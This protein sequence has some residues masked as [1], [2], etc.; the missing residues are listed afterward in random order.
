MR[1]VPFSPEYLRL[2]DALPFGV[3]DANGRLLLSAGQVVC[4]PGQ[5][6]HLRSQ[7]LFCDEAESANWRR[8]LAATMDRMIRSNV[9]LKSISEALP[10]A[11]AREVGIEVERTLGDQW[12]TVVTQLDAVLRDI[13]P[14]SDWRDRLD[15][16]H[17][18]ARALAARRLDATLY[19]LIYTAGH[20]VERYSC[21][22]ALLTLVIAEQAASLLGW[23]QPDVD[24][25][26]RAALTMNVSMVRLQDLLATTTQAPTDE[27]RREIARHAER[28]AG[29]LADAGASDPLWLGAVRLHHDIGDAGPGPDDSTPAL[30]LARLLRRV[31]IFAAKLSRRATRMPL[32]PVQAAREAC[33]G[34]DG[35]PDEIGAGLLKAVGLYPPGCF[36][37]LACG[38]VG[39]VVSRGRRAN[40]PLVVSLV[41]PTGMPLGEPTLRDTIDPRFAVRG[42]VPVDQVKLHPP[43]ERVL[44]MG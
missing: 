14:A 24:A 43:H 23:P 37:E 39:I 20:F 13:H 38:E 25:L 4:D 1:L 40:L 31:D 2:S 27:M 33:L 42:A 16:V 41:A 12:G 22:H 17:Q 44:A 30:R 9:S 6:S 34:P 3:R 7:P 5:L 18:R 26:G 10:D 11:D 29:M 15:I 36:V 21:H 19:L 28:S 8:R 32:S 35:R